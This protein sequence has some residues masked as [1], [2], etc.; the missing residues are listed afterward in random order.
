[1]KLIYSLL[2]N[3]FNMPKKKNMQMQQSSSPNNALAKQRNIREHKFFDN[4]PIISI[5]FST[6]RL[7]AAGVQ[8]QLHGITKI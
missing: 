7:F 4:G 6:Q 1:M 8:N 3:K 5:Q 2:K